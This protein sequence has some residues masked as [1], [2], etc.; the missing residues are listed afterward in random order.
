MAQSGRY[1]DALRQRDFALFATS[2]LIDEVGSWSY[3]V[4]IAVDVYDRTHSTVWLAG[5]SASRWIIGLLLSGYAGVIADR[6]ERTQSHARLRL[7]LRLSDGRYRGLGRPQRPGVDAAGAH[8]DLGNR[9]LAVPLGG[10]RADSRGGCGE[11]PGGGERAVR[12]VG[13]PGRRPRPGDRWPAAARR[14]RPSSAW[15]STP[16]S[17]FVAAAIILRLRIRSRGTIEPGS[18][19]LTQWLV[20]FRVLAS[21]QVALALVAF[22]ALDSMVYGAS[23][24]IYAPLSVHLGTGVNGYSYLLAGNALGWRHRCRSCE[25]AECIAEAGACYRGQHRV[26]G[27]AVCGDDAGPFRRS[28]VRPSGRVWRRHGH[29]RCSRDHRASARSRWR[30][31]ESG[32]WRLRRDH[33]GR[34]VDRQFRHCGGVVEPGRRDRPCGDRRWHSGAW[35]LSGCRCSCAAIALRLRSRSVGATG[36]VVGQP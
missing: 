9:G 10:R 11:G 25:P 29:R 36:R 18:G 32:A 34:G 23:T 28:R 2:A 27:V 20:G 24:V 13:E 5:L 22:C 17:F 19:I 12:D 3:S 30:R 35:R 8:R 16:A 15:P 14:V 26:A 33:H 31:H 6:Y 7:G 21:H 1:R 4:V